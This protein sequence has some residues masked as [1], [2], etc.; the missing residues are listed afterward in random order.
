[1]KHLARF[2]KRGGDPEGGNPRRKQVIHQDFTV[3]VG[4]VRGAKEIV[5]KPSTFYLRRSR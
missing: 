2:V 3:L 1:M 4:I 5:S